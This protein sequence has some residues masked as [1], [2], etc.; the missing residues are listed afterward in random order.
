MDLESQARMRTAGVGQQD[1]GA[2][3]RQGRHD[4]KENLDCMSG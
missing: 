1:G 4:G 2:R 3:Y